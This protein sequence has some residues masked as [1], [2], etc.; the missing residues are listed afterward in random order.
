MGHEQE[1]KIG[2]LEKEEEKE[3]KSFFCEFR[4]HVNIA[5]YRLVTGLT[6]YN[7]QGRSDS[8]EV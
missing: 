7:M 8:L 5:A 3:E 1:N 2:D 6:F 4:G